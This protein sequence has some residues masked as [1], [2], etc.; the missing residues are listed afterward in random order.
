MNKCDETIFMKKMGRIKVQMISD[1][2]RGYALPP[3]KHVCAKMFPHQAYIRE[4][5]ERNGIDG[6]C[7]YSGKHENVLP[8]STIVDMVMSAFTEIFENPANEIPFESH[9]MWDDLEGTGLHK[10]GAGYILPDDKSIMTTEEAL[11]EAGFIPASDELF[12]DIAGCF[13]S[14]DWVVKD[15]LVGTEDERLANNWQQFWDG[16]I[17]DSQSQ[18]P[19]DT[20]YKHHAAL[21]SYLSNTIGSNLHSLR[22]TL[23]KDSLL[24]RCVNYNPVPNPLLAENLWA[25]PA[26]YASSQRMSRK[27]QSRFYASFDRETPLSE[28]VNNGGNEFHCLGT[29]RLKQEV[30]LLDFTNIPEPYILNVPDYF[31]YR[32]LYGF[33]NAITQHVG[34]SDSE[35]HK[36]V[37]TQIMRDLI[38]NDFS[39]AGIMGIKYRSVKNDG[40]PNVVLFLDNNTCGDCLELIDKEIIS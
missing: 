27:G 11:Y 26:A 35:K 30:S 8:L 19:Y 9:G 34:E 18:V 36:Y 38:E 12:D 15:A 28:A 22:T 24:Y 39:R 33:Q 3:D 32:F 13:L 20:I 40:Q 5:I 7:S 6:V 14:D 25:P 31:A 29:F 37:P 1:E 17:T 21:L 16:T 4:R 23:P 2:M 10:V